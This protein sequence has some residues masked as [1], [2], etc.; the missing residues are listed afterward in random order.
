MRYKQR[1]D[2]EGFIDGRNY[3]MNEMATLLKKFSKIEP[4]QTTTGTI[5]V[6]SHDQS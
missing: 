6:S 2:G 5:E 4:F 3:V 1:E